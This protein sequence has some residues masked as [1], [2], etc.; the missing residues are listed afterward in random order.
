MNRKKKEFFEKDGWTFV[1]TLIVM[2]IVL[3]MTASV[4]F[5]S[6][7]QLDKARVVTAKSQIDAFSIALESYYMDVGNYPSEQDGL[8]CLWDKSFCNSD[9]WNGPYVT[10]QIPKDPWGNDYV[11]LCP[12][13]NGLPWTIVSYGKDS[14]EGGEGYD[15]D[16]TSDE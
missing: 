4:G 13:R 1:E 14:M 11:Y 16:I 12:G 6:I 2:A 3:V 7:K 10:K 5:S 8:N 9:K 15:G